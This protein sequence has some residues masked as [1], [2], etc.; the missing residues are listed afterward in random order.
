MELKSPAT[1]HNNL[2]ITSFL[3]VVKFFVFKAKKRGG[4]LWRGQDINGQEKE[5]WN[6]QMLSGRPNSTEHRLA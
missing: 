3:N 2:E 6:G 4:R 1:N 5:S